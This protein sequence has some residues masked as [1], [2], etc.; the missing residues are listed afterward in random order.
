MPVIRGRSTATAVTPERRAQLRERL[1]RERSGPGTP[2]GPLI[3][4]I[5]LEQSDQVDVIVVWNEFQGVRVEDRDRV[6]LDAY[7]DRRDQIAMAMGVTYQ[8][9]IDQ[10]V[11]PYAV[12]PMAH[13]GEVDLA[14]LRKAMLEEG[15]IALD[16]GKVDLRFPTLAMAEAAHHRLCE[17]LPQ[18]YWS[19]SQTVAPIP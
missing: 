3:F 2:E 15:G 19:I 13:R 10:H 6:I 11:L 12:I 16:D 9:A 1:T 8:E 18:G 14:D 5:P 4:E 7:Q 17:R